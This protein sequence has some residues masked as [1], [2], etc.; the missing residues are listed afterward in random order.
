MNP[1][2]DPS[3]PPRPRISWFARLAGLAWIILCFE[4]G[5]FLLVYPWMEGWERNE[6]A[7]WRPGARELWAN[8]FVRGAVSGLGVVNIGISLRN[9]YSYL[10]QLLFD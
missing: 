3:P 4:L 6:I 5:V 9:L 8:P 10:R 1:L 7:N 2:P